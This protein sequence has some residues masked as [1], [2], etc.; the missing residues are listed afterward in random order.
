M[1]EAPDFDLL[2]ASLRADAT[3]NR[4][5]LEVLAGK[6]ETALPG[7]VEVRRAG[8]LLRRDHPV[9]DI[10]LSLGDWRFH[11]A[12]HGG[13]NVRA[14]RTHLVGGI[15]LKSEPLELDAWIGALAEAL[16]AH[17]KSN[18][19]AAAALHQFLS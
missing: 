16:V 14:E 1:A 19:I 11:L 3:D 18:A 9:T 6:L 10:T 12:T 13:A 5:F 8:G 7:G 4:T 17:A 2:A 15:A